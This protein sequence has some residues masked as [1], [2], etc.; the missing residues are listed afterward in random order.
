MP[1]TRRESLKRKAHQGHQSALLTGLRRKDGADA[2][3]LKRPRAGPTPFGEHKG[4]LC[5][6][7]D[8]NPPPEKKPPHVDAGLR[9]LSAEPPESLAETDQASQ[10]CHT[11]RLDA[12]QCALSSEPFE[13]V[14]ER[15][16]ASHL[17]TK[18]HLDA[19]SRSLS[20]VAPEWVAE[21]HK[22]SELSAELHWDAGRGALSADPS[23]YS[24]VARSSQDKSSQDSA[25][26]RF[27]PDCDCAPPEFDAERLPDLVA[28]LQRAPYCISKAQDD[29]R[30]VLW[31]DI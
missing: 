10:L 30:R 17:C 20:A 19:G 25:L 13:F 12:G 31:I 29:S 2:G 11:P 28:L 5:P 24:T 8:T 1:S 22:T 27:S 7:F 14:A 4:T 18:A 23:Q 21:T 16:K 6:L 3:L 9:G 26:L 15:D